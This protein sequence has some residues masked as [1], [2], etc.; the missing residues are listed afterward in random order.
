MSEPRI[1]HDLLLGPHKLDDILRAFE[2]LLQWSL[3]NFKRLSVPLLADYFAHLHRAGIAQ[4]RCFN[5]GILYYDGS[6]FVT[7]EN[8][9]APLNRAEVERLLKLV[10]AKAEAMNADIVSSIQ[11]RRIYLYGSCLRGA[12]APND[13][14]LGIEIHREDGTSVPVPDP[15]PFGPP[16][17]FDDAA[18]PLALRK[19]RIISLLH[20]GEVQAIGAPHR[21]IWEAGRGR[22]V[23]EPLQTPV[24]TSET[25]DTHEEKQQQHA[26]KQKTL[27]AW[28]KKVR[29]IQDWPVMP[30][31]PP[32]KDAVASL[33]QYQDW[34]DNQLL[35]MRAHLHCLPDGPLKEDIQRQMDA[36]LAQSPEL[37]QQWEAAAPIILPFIHASQQHSPWSLRPDGRL[38]KSSSRPTQPP[39]HARSWFSRLFL[40][41][42]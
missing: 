29:K 19:P 27:D 41:R 35:L 14:D 18:R 40:R 3:C 1:P 16:S 32:T 2:G 17:E 9:R 6:L 21:L 5:D 31:I 8:L 30:S 39:H 37:R 23:N 13:I 42:V 38:V 4:P 28:V 11:V 7:R 25:C 26:T 22:L 10:C 24:R 12:E 33:E 34:Q 36:H 20:I 15:D